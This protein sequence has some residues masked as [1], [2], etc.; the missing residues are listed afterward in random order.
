[1][2]HPLRYKRVLVTGGT[3][4]LGSGVVK[5]IL[6]YEPDV[7]RVF[8]R[9]ETKQHEM[10]G[11]LGENARV[12]YLIGDVRDKDRLRMACEGIQFVI[13]A[14]AMKHVPA[15]EYNPFEAVA[16]NISGTQNV[17]EAARERG[18]E[19]LVVVSTDKAAEPES[20]MGAT[21]LVAE[22]VALAAAQWSNPPR[23][24]CVRLGNVLGSRGSIVPTIRE[25]LA[26]GK[27]ITIT[28]PTMTRF[29]MTPQAASEFIIRALVSCGGGEL[30]VPK[31]R[32][33]CVGDLVAVIT[34]RPISSFPCT[35]ARPGEKLHEL[36][37]SEDEQKR[38]LELD[39]A[40][41]VNTEPVSHKIPCGRF[42]SL[43]ADW[44][45]RKE[46]GRLLEETG[47]GNGTA[48]TDCHCQS[49]ACQSRQDG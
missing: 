29:V 2:N 35:G 4:S 18:V 49:G 8:S 11:Q 14:A 26:G 22:R 37:L 23:I 21:K 6:K 3:G 45:T 32:A 24:C 7:I 31:L 25:R 19:R 1:M 46:I 48:D 36:L 9:D 47:T 38:A 10:R 39:W 44:L 34:G 43:T 12:R 30:Y 28:D 41:Y 5:E 20:V 17:I 40:Y 13:H 33:V 27:Q 15:C 42:G 16:T